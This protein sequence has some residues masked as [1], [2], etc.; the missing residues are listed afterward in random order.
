MLKREDIIE[1]L[2]D[3][4]YTKKSAAYIIDDFV[5]VIEEALVDG[6]EV[7][8]HGF[9]TFRVLHTKPR[10]MQ[11]YQT[12]ETISVPTHKAPKFVPGAQLRRWV[13]EGIIRD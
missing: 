6:E 10:D 1:R 13:R 8:I 2:A 3:K 9:G 12:K 7:M 4:G 11:D 5:R